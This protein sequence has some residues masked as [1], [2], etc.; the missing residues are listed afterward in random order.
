VDSVRGLAAGAVLALVAWQAGASVL[1][2]R[3]ELLGRPRAQHLLALRSTPEELIARTLGEDFELWLAL[4]AHL[5]AEATVVVS[6]PAQ[7]GF[8]GLMKRLTPLVTLAYPLRFKGWPC[9]A[10]RAAREE[11]W[12]A[13]G[14]VYVLE[15]E[16]GRD[17]SRWARQEE[18]AR[19]PRFRLLVLGSVAR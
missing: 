12:A 11:P 16:S 13:P 17:Y 2:V 5:P 19:G 4:H 15:L 1:N 10:R 7:L 9:D 18:L 14:D 3:A 8:T 6:Y